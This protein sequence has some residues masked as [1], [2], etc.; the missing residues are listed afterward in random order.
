[1]YKGLAGGSLVPIFSGGLWTSPISI[2]V[3]TMSLMI[4][5]LFGSYR[6]ISNDRIGVKRL[7]ESSSDLSQ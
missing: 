7:I 1:M 2:Q 4:V 6:F 5:R 3:N